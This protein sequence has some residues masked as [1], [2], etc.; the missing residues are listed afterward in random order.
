[1]EFSL[2]L[3]M[4]L[5]DNPHLLS[6]ELEGGKDRKSFLSERAN[7]INCN[8][9]TRHQDASELEQICL[10]DLELKA[11]QVEQAVDPLLDLLSCVRHTS[12]TW[13]LEHQFG[14]EAKVLLQT[15][16]KAERD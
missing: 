13:A 14:M 5:L 2:L 11:G 3:R 16:W 8:G 15:A 4:N 7:G 12:G 1:M 9:L 6:L 10:S